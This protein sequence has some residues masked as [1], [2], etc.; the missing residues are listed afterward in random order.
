MRDIIS[1]ILKEDLSDFSGWV[2]VKIDNELNKRIERLMKGLGFRGGDIRNK[3]IFLSDP[4][5]GR[6]RPGESIGQA[7]NRKISAMM[8]LQY[9]KELKDLFN[10]SS[11]GFLFESFIAGLLGGEQVPGTGAV[12]VTT[13]TEK[14]QIKF[15]QKKSSSIKKPASLKDVPTKIIL[16]IKEPES[17]TIYQ[18]DYNLFLSKASGKSDSINIE[19]FIKLADNLGTLNLSNI[20]TMSDELHADLSVSISSLWEIIS[21]LQFN[22]ESML[23]GITKGGEKTTTLKAANAAQNNTRQLDSKI[24]ELRSFFKPRTLA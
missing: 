18:M 5:H 15:Y 2:N 13:S 12:D 21:E 4:I 19:N 7:L 17:V 14:Y 8:L 9:L 10:S 6:I 20:D 3:I 22:V 23:T 1:K 16:G 24:E 11:A